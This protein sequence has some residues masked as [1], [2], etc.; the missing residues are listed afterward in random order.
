MIICLLFLMI[1]TEGSSL[2]MQGGG[3]TGTRTR[4][5]K[6]LK[7]QEM[8]WQSFRLKNWC[9]LF[10]WSENWVHHLL[11]KK[12][13]IILSPFV[14]WNQQPRNMWKLWYISPPQSAQPMDSN[15]ITVRSTIIGSRNVV[16]SNK[17]REWR[18]WRYWWFFSMHSGSEKK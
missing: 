16:Q 4:N 9:K 18:V 6:L 13:K 11:S 17:C 2:M 10:H 8:T 14:E 15:A 5:A 3:W 1:K 7:I 12:V